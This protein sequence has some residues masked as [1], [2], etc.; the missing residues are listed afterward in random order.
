MKGYRLSIVRHGLTS[1]NDSGVYI[2]SRSDYSLSQ[3]GISHLSIKR[4]NLIIRRFRE[5]IQVQ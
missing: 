5:Y 4:T 3:K 1:A 2:G